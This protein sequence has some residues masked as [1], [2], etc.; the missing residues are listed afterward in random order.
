MRLGERRHQAR[1]CDRRKE[2]ERPPI[3]A[4]SEV[5]AALTWEAA[6][7]SGFVSHVTSGLV[8]GIVDIRLCE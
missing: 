5:L 6:K 8:Y 2:F 7:L 1:L 4:E 3:N